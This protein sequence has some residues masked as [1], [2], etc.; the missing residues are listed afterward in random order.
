MVRCSMLDWPKD[1]HH[2]ISSDKQLLGCH[3][4]SISG[5]DAGF[6]YV[7]TPIRYQDANTHGSEAK[8]QLVRSLSYLFQHDPRLSWLGWEGILEG[9]G[10]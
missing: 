10:Q 1:L 3:P 9:E 7:D 8:A 4:S 6:G 2:E 5:T